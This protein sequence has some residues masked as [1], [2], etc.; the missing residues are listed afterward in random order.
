MK[1]GEHQIHKVINPVERAGYIILHPKLHIASAMKA[2]NNLT[3]GLLAAKKRGSF[4]LFDTLANS[5]QSSQ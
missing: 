5:N 2:A 4:N 3:D 1:N